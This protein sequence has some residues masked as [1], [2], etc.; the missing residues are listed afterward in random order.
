MLAGVFGA[1]WFVATAFAAHLP[2]LPEAL[3][4]TPAAAVFAGSLVGPAQVTAR[5]IE[6]SVLRLATTDDSGATRR[7]LLSSNSI[8][9]T[10]SPV[11]SL[12]FST[13]GR[14]VIPG[15]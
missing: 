9:A 8:S 12:L 4:A 7:L 3:G 11:F 2:R 1:T 5:L 15:S 13:I 14:L 10:P 6:F